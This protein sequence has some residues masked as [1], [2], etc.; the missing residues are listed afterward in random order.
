MSCQSLL[1]VDLSHTQHQAK[2]KNEVVSI[3]L[4][5]GIPV[6][7]AVGTSL[8]CTARLIS[9]SK[10]MVIGLVSGKLMQ[11]LGKFIDKERQKYFQNKEN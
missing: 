6:V 10:A 11:E 3:T 1:Q 4:T 8:L 5:Q 7:S 2:D 9:G